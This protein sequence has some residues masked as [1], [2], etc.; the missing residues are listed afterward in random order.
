MCFFCSTLHDFDDK[1]LKMKKSRNKSVVD[2]DKLAFQ[3]VENLHNNNNNSKNRRFS[4]TPSLLS[5][6]VSFFFVLF[7]CKF[8]LLASNFS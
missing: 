3:L 5:V 7:T 8:G 2:F 4:V 1:F 6:C